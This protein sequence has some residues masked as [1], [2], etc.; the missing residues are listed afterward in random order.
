M[1]LPGSG[2]NG[3]EILPEL[4][5]KGAG[6]GQ[7]FFRDRVEEGKAPGME[8]D[9][10]KRHRIAATSGIE[11]IADKRTAD[12]PHMDPDLMGP[13][14]VDAA[15]DKRAAPRRPEPPERSQ[16]FAASAVDSHS[17]AVE[18]IPPDGSI[19]LPFEGRRSL[20]QRQIALVDVAIPEGVDHGFLSRPVTS[21]DHQARGGSIEPMDNAGADDAV[22]DADIRIAPEQTVDKSAP[23]VARSG[24]HDKAGRFVDNED[25]RI[26]VDNIEGHRLRLDFGTLR[27]RKR[28][29]VA[30]SLADP[31]SR[32]CFASF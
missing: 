18:T 20:D 16:S 4:I 11:I 3:S 23:P 19:N 1:P 26:F 30:F 6:K 21:D 12:M 7:R 17:Q 24:M 9:P 5:G 22:G 13:P 8:E 2:E 25:M 28:D 32:L 15:N 10:V 14:R 27:R 29:L 31:K